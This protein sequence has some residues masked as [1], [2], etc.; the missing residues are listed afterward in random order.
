MAEPYAFFDW[1]RDARREIA[2]RGETPVALAVE[3]GAS[4]FE[5]PDPRVTAAKAP[6]TEPDPRGRIRR[7]AGEF[8]LVEST[9]VPAD[10]APGDTARVHVTFRP[11]V[12]TKAHWNNS[13]DP[14]V[15]WM[16]PPAGVAVAARA[17]VAP[18]A[19]T[20]VSQETRTVE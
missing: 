3:P 12:G 18:N 19:D 11:N 5:T 16:S 15:Y 8:V 7:D 14:L 20:E 17:L 4:E 1:I 9:T 10:P 13:V 2:A 6:A